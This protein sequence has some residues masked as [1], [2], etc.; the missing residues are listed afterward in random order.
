MLNKKFIFALGMLSAL[1]TTQSFASEMDD[2][3]KLATGM[4]KEAA[5]FYNS[6]NFEKVKT[7]FNDPASTEWLRQPYHLHMFGMSTNN[8]TVWADNVFP[9]FVGMDFRTMSD[10]N[11]KDFGQ[12][13]FDNTKSATD[14]YGIEISFTNPESGNIVHGFGACLKPDAK[15]IICTWTE[16]N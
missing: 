7:A 6:N 14:T 13:I 10:M 1:T 11:G 5:Q 2:M 9:E 12:L 4:V 8:A 3:K 16:G 15:N